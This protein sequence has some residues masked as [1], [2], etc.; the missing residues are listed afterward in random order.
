MDIIKSAYKLIFK[1][2]RNYGKILIILLASRLAKTT[3]ISSIK[4]NEGVHVSGDIDI[5]NTINDYFSNIGADLSSKLPESET[6]PRDYINESTNQF[7]FKDITQ[8]MVYNILNSLKSSKL[9]RF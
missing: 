8:S 3:C 4:V 7:K 6:N 9:S 2:Q 1:I 5:A